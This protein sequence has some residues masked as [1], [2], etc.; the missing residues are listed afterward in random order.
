MLCFMAGANSIFVGDKLLTTTNPSPGQDELLFDDLGLTPMPSHAATLAGL[1][2]AWLVLDASILEG[3]SSR[4]RC[5]PARRRTT[6]QDQSSRR[7][8]D[9]QARVILMSSVVESYASHV[10]RRERPLIRALGD[11]LVG[12]PVPV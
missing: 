5:E 12:R 3:P 1:I 4:A 10:R 11:P 2:R 9:V 7:R 6:C 8:F